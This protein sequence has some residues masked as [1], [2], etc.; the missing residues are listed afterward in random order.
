MAK[1]NRARETSCYREAQLKKA[2]RVQ[3]AYEQGAITKNEKDNMI[4][5]IF[6]KRLDK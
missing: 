1:E 3:K 2:G 6:T 4:K 5:E